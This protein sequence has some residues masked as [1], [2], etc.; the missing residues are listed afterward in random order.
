MTIILHVGAGKCG[1]S[2]LQAQLSSCPLLS[3]D[4]GSAHYEYVCI[5]GNG[6]LLRR[7]T[8]QRQ[9]RLTPYE[10]EVSAGAEKPWATDAATLEQLSLQL[11]DVLAHGRTPI[12]SQESWLGQAR[13]FKDNEI[14]PQLGLRAKVVVFVRPQILWL[15]SAWWQWGVWLPNS[16]HN[17]V[18]NNKHS[19]RWTTMT[20]AWRSVPGVDEVE[21]HAACGDVVATF[22]RSIGIAVEGAKRRNVSLDENLLSYLR[23]RPDL[24]PSH[25]PLVEFILE[26]RLAANARGSPWVLPHEQ[27]SDLIE[28][29]RADNLDL[30]S[31]VSSDARQAI[32]DDPM[33]WDAAAY[34]EHE[35]IPAEF[36]EPG[37]EALKDVAGRAIDAVIS[38]DGRV[39]ILE[40]SQRELILA[41]EAQRQITR[42]AEAKHYELTQAAEAAQCEFTREAEAARFELARTIEAAKPKPMAVRLRKAISINGIRRMVGA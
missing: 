42:A 40:E 12:A 26:Q 21:I 30:L 19:A 8:I 35:V 6:D 33:W 20:D 15:N 13:I 7:E 28:Y 32:E 22:F 37:V 1:S 27:I 9:A 16:F 38:L 23:T 11:R 5:T 14:L 3:A 18:E 4:D 25:S 39:R 10:V 17:F 31:L 24:R 29:Y 36:A 2:S 41:L 34:R